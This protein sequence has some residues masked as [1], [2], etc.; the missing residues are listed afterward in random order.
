MSKLK[1]VD[2]AVLNMQPASFEM[3]S[4]ECVCLSGP[5]GEGKSQLLRAMADLIPHQG[6]VWLNDQPCQSMAPSKWRR[7]VGLLMAESQW[8]AV[9]VGE[10]FHN[11]D[12]ELFNELGFNKD[13]LNW[14]IKRCSS[15]EKQRLALLRLLQHKPEALLLDEPTASLDPASVERLENLLAVYQQEHSANVIWVTHDPLQIKRVG[16]RHFELS[17]GII[18]E[19][20]L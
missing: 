6:E 9:H 15:G 16:Q 10:H 17:K 19:V 2:L 3:K 1:V 5:S 13:V 8:W 11:V 20:T 14:E 4:G 12:M 7:K 18:N